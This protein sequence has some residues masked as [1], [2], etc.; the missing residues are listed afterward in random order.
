MSRMLHNEIVAEKAVIHS[1]NPVIRRGFPDQT[2]EFPTQLFAASLGFFVA[3]LVVMTIGFGNPALAIPMAICAVFLV[4]FFGIPALFVREAPDH[5]NKAMSWGQ[6]RMRGIDTLT[7]RLPAG[8]AV[9]QML[10]LPVL[11]LIWGLACIVIA[12]LV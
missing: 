8:E 9:V 10:I 3:F 6:F 4:G 5:A 2:F 1:E 7:G 12:A 11:L